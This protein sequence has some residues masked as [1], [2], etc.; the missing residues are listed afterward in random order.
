VAVAGHSAG[1]T[2]QDDWGQG[3]ASLQICMHRTVGKVTAIN[4]SVTSCVGLDTA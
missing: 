3:K 4:A 1:P 2:A